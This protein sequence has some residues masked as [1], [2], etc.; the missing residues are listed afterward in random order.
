MTE[1]GNTPV[2]AGL[3]ETLGFWLKDTSLQANRSITEVSRMALQLGEDAPCNA[4]AS[5]SGR[6]IHPLNLGCVIGNAANRTTTD[7]LAAKTG[8]EKDG[9]FHRSFGRRKRAGRSAISLAHFRAEVMDEFSGCLTDRIL[10]GDGQR[11]CVS[12]AWKFCAHNHAPGSYWEA[13]GFGPI[14][15]FSQSGMLSRQ[16]TACK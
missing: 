11:G 3:V 14:E 9:P 8:N 7:G 6:D 1:G 16:P 4:L 2:A 10:W 13:A 12:R 15:N 5:S